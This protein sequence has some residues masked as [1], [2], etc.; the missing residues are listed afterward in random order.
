MSDPEQCRACHGPLTVSNTENI[1]LCLCHWNIW[2]GKHMV[3][4]PGHNP[5]P[6]P[7]NAHLI[8]A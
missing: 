6:A 5:E 8:T 4:Y 7:C 2:L 1:P 3:A